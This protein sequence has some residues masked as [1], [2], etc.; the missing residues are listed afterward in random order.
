MREQR[1]IIAQETL[2]IQQQGFY[3]TPSNNR[4]DIS[5]LQK[6]SENE[7]FAL[8]PEQG[9]QIIQGLPQSSSTTKAVYKVVNQSTVQA[10]IDA[11]VSN[12]RIAALNFASAKNPGGGF[13]SGAIAQEEALAISSGLYNT[14]IRHEKTFYAVNRA[15]RSMMY[16]DNAIYS[17]DVVFFRDTYFN[18]LEM[19]VT[20]SVLTLPAVNMGQVR[21]KGESV[22]QA[23]IV[24]KNRMRLCLSIL[25][26]EENDVII[27]GA[28]GCG[29]FKNDPVE[30]VNWWRE[31]L[32]DEN[33]ELY[34]NDVIFAILDNSDGNIIKLFENKFF[35]V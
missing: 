4:I 16:T 31:L 20:S 19:P 12:K 8:T 13:L 3:F 14:L 1:K 15:C 33:Y 18:L 10:V 27:L 5:D 7:S 17:P 21:I 22:S 28:Y 26:K 11:S 30:V 25:A 6:R 23:K 24:M 35:K 32:V 34:F 29:V 9:N 2:K